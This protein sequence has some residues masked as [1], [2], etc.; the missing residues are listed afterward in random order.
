M[1]YVPSFS[2]SLLYYRKS[3][4]SCCYTVCYYRYAI[5][6][7]ILDVVDLY[8]KYIIYHPDHGIDSAVVVLH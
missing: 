1:K 8:A 5:G 7:F 6:T 3:C 4:I 2:L